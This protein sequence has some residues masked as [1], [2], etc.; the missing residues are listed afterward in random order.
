M[1]RAQAIKYQSSIREFAQIDHWRAPHAVT[2]TMKQGIH[3]ANGRQFAM[4]FLD[5]RK[6]AQN[7]SHFHTI[8]SRKVLGTPAKRFGERLPMIPVIEG[9]NGKR[10]HYHTLI[11]CPRDE[12]AAEFPALIRETWLKTQW[13]YREID[14]QS[15]A[16]DGFLFYMTKLRDKPNYAD[17]VDWMNYYNPD[18]RV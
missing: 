13:G 6:A 1:N 3:V 12:F 7:L 9:G 4:T 8:L 18:R 14:I 5:N 17:A 2:L 11:D 10:L 15:Q 16:D